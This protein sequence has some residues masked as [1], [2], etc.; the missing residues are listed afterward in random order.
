VNSVLENFGVVGA[1]HASRGNF[2]SHSGVQ[3]DDVF[4]QCQLSGEPDKGELGL[5]ECECSP[6]Q[7]QAEHAQVPIQGSAQVPF[8]H[9]ARMELNGQE[10]E[11]EEE[12]VPGLLE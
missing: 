7:L 1:R 10:L 6:R 5:D 11:S 3:V 12:D 9:Q 8:N 4:D 2:A